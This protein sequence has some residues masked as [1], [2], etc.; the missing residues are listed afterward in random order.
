M[1][2]WIRSFKMAA[3][4]G[5]IGVFSCTAHTRNVHTLINP[6]SVFFSFNFC[7][8]KWL[9]FFINGTF[10]YFFHRIVQNVHVINFIEPIHNW[11]IWS[12]FSLR[13][14]CRRICG[15]IY[16]NA[17]F[18]STPVNFCNI[19]CIIMLSFLVVGT[20]TVADELYVKNGDGN[21]EHYYSLLT[22]SSPKSLI[23]FNSSMIG[24]MFPFSYQ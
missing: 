15:S 4:C 23:I 22:P 6:L 10:V 2:P 12:T 14:S 17:Q 13:F 24:D 21:D 16:Q 20:Y 19:Y 9:I 7:R 3:F 11:H 18:L 1:Y 8:T 5:S